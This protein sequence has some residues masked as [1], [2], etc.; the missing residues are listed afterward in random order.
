MKIDQGLIRYYNIILKKNKNAQ[1]Y[2][3]SRG[4]DDINLLIE[5]YK[6]GF[7]LHGYWARFF[8]HHCKHG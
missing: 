7:A 2:L 4:F 6:L 8:K 1:E 3:K 5:K